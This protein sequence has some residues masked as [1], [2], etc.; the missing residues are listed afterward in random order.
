VTMTITM[1]MV[2]M[3]IIIIVWRLVWMVEKDHVVHSCGT[4]NMSVFLSF[5]D[6]YCD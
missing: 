5:F 6:S 4:M 3:M 2:M 1:M